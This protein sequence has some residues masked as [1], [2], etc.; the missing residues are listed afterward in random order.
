MGP[1]STEHRV[2]TARM[3]DLREATAFAERFC[4]ERG[5]DDNARWHLILVLEELFTNTVS[6]GFRGG[7]DAPIV[8]ALSHDGPAITLRYEDPAPAFNP[9]AVATAA[10]AAA[11]DARPVGGLGM[12]LV[13]EVARDL[14]YRYEDGRNRLTLRVPVEASTGR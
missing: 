12:M 9:F 8:V 11:P 10:A 5:I 4:R 14:S 2:F 1:N 3:A 6:H 13:A 7:A